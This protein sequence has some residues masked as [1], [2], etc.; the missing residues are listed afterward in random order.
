MFSLAINE[1]IVVGSLV[2]DQEQHSLLLIMN[3]VGIILLVYS[4]WT[5]TGS[6]VLVFIKLNSISR[7]NI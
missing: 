4:G 3:Y 2:Q 6:N 7:F 1:E 5:F